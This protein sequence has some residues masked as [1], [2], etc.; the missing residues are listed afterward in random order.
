MNSGNDL[1]IRSLNLEFFKQTNVSGEVFWFEAVAT[2]RFFVDRFSMRKEMI[3]FSEI[4]R[5]VTGPGSFIGV[6]KLLKSGIFT[7]RHGAWKFHGYSVIFG[8]WNEKVCVHVCTVSF[9]GTSLMFA[10]FAA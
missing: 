9:L 2:G 6:R 4:S 3:I 7:W 1:E 8:T 5:M 10:F